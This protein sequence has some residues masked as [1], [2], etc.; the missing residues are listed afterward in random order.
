MKSLKIEDHNDSRI[1]HGWRA[2]VGN[3]NNYLFMHKHHMTQQTPSH[4]SKGVAISN[5]EI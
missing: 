1:G 5:I 4:T 3:D 2:H